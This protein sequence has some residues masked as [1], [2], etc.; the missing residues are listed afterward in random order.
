MRF[1]SVFK[2]CFTSHCSCSCCCCFT[3]N[4]SVF[5]QW[6]G[7]ETLKPLV[8]SSLH[9]TLCH[10]AL[11]W[12]G[13]AW[14][15]PNHVMRIHAWVQPVVRRAQTQTLML[16][17]ASELKWDWDAAWKNGTKLGFK[18]VSILWILKL[19]IIKIGFIIFFRKKNEF[20]L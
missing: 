9:L 8:F 13:L 16:H 15:G 14:L 17:T 5:S 20:C 6:N 19:K 4:Y 12:P 2:T 7:G 3:S 1:L 18:K 10:F 11:A